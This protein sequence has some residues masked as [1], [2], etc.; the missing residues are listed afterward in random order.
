[1]TKYP[2]NF[3]S[4]HQI[5]PVQNPKNKL[6]P[7]GLIREFT[8][9]KKEYCKQFTNTAFVV[10]F[11]YVVDLPPDHDANAMPSTYCSTAAHIASILAI[12]SPLIA[13]FGS[14]SM[15][16]R[17]AESQ[18]RKFLLSVKKATVYYARYLSP[19]VSSTMF[20]T[21]FAFTGRF[22]KFCQLTEEFKTT[23]TYWGCRHSLIMPSRNKLEERFYIHILLSSFLLL[24]LS[25]PPYILT[26]LGFSPPKTTLYR[27]ELTVGFETN[28]NSNA[29]RKHEKYHQL[30][31]DL[32]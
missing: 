7:R 18:I 24:L 22:E 32:S 29:E 30:T 12:L 15:Y 4:P 25:I 14:S 17:S 26:F 13:I 23:P 3:L 2:E 19:I 28:L 9:G 10:N 11:D 21:C 16:C 6:V 1:M 8:V 31:R 5:S 27:I 20:S